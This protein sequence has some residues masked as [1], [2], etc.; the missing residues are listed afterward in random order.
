MPVDAARDYAQIEH[1]IPY[2]QV[3]STLGY[4]KNPPAEYLLPGVDVIGGMRQIQD[5]LVADA[6][7]SQYD[8][9]LDVANIFWQAA[10]GHFAYGP[11]LLHVFRF[12][13]NMPLISVS[14]DGVQLPKVYFKDDLD[15]SRDSNY[16]VSDIVSID[17]Q[18]IV[19]YL[20]A[21]S[22]SSLSQ[23]PDAKYN[24][25]FGSI[26]LSSAGD[27]NGFAVGS[28]VA[29]P[30]Q[31]LASFSNGSTIPFNNVAVVGQSLVNITDGTDLHLA[32]EIPPPPSPTTPTPPQTANSTFPNTTTTAVPSSSPSAAPAPLPTVEGYPYPVLKHANN[33]LAGYFLNDTEHAD[34]A[35]LAIY[36]FELDPENP[37]VDDLQE[38]RRVVRIFLEA[39]QEAGK[40]K[41]IIDL[42]ANG[43]G[44]I[45]E[46]FELYRSLFPQSVPF[47]G[48]RFR[49][50]DAF[51][52]IGQALYGSTE[53]T[54]LFGDNLDGHLN[55]Y[56]TWESL[57]G[58]AAFSQDNE[59]ELLRYNFSNPS[60]TGGDAPFLI[61]GYNLSDTPAGPAVPAPGHGG[62]DG[63]HLRVHV[64]HLRRPDDAPGRRSHHR[65]GRPPH[66]RGPCRP[67]AASKGSQVL[68]FSIIRE[69]T[70]IA[71][72]SSN[73]TTLPAGLPSREDPP[74]VSNA[75]YGSFNMR[76]AY[77]VDRPDMPLQFVYE[78][79]NCRR[80][81]TS[82]TLADMTTLWGSLA[83][84]AWHGAK[85][86]S[87]STVNADD[88]IGNVAPSF[89]TSNVVPWRAPAYTGPGSPAYKPAAPKD[90]IAIRADQLAPSDLS[91]LPG[92]K[93][94]L[95]H[96]MP[97]L[98]NHSNF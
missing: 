15:K 45:F 90:T 27:G 57:Y 76:N 10:D 32:Y 66:R 33:Y 47:D 26:P 29:L 25:L 38:L 80:F 77:A 61:S 7:E 75:D 84:V 9:S 42:S 53:G 79:A 71:A 48:S 5:K 41:L 21:L 86:V 91:N 89:S 54:E 6:Y 94:E 44:L 98:P 22:R 67:L 31:S 69:F 55:L 60:L 63:R 78:A 65:P 19:E 13:P 74:L 14:V 97:K 23:D 70:T 96:R 93:L 28:A 20:E 35:V 51:D 36:A 49:A 1:L 43:G 72:Q 82:D 11:P 95:L 34:V 73:L 39:C 16:E 30:D 3:Q 64:H 68:K 59:T 87:G 2:L 8:W 52:F 40:T 92:A 12:A 58:P 18:P 83:D 81:Y 50:T 37:N 62:G 46:G 17:G 88:T 4:L 24:S 85:C 56:P